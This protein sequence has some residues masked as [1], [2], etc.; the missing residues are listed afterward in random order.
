VFEF[1]NGLWF[2]AQLYVFLIGFLIYH[3][4]KRG[5]L[6]AVTGRFGSSC[7]LCWSL[8]VFFNVVKTDFVFINFTLAAI[9]IAISDGASKFVNPVIC[10]IGKISYSCYLAH[11]FAL[12]TALKLL[13]IKLTADSTF[14]DAGGAFPNCLLFVKLFTLALLFTV[15]ISTATLHLI[16]SPGI[17]LGKKIIRWLSQLNHK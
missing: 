4:L 13:G 11:F 6:S 9:I 10:Y 15:L 14:F 17:K 2:P 5:H 1:F 12:G 3:L 7:V 16:E 8:M